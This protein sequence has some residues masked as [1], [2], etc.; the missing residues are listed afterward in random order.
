MSTCS[1]QI[2]TTES[3][4]KSGQNLSH[5]QG[6]DFRDAQT[7]KNKNYVVFFFNFTCKITWSLQGQNK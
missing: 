7:K 4:N 3:E 6:G 2:N 5:P 1:Y